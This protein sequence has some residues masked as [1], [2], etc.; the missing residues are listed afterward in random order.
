MTLC[1]LTLTHY[2]NTRAPDHQTAKTIAY[3][4]MLTLA[5]DRLIVCQPGKSCYLN[6]IKV[7]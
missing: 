1:S 2:V 7:Q 5:D 6:I 4:E 3:T